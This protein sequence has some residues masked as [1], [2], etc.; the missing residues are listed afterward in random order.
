MGIN[1]IGYAELWR[2]ML[3]RMGIVTSDPLKEMLIEKDK[4]LKEN[5]IKSELGKNRLKRTEKFR[6]KII[7][8]IKQDQ[9]AHKE[10]KT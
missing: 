9:V 6:T 10:G 1:I 4:N 2:L 3:K 7:E 5:G 8:Q